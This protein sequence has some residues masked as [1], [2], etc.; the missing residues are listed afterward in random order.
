MAGDGALNPC[1]ECAQGKCANCIGE[2]WDPE[3][4]DVV[5]VCPCAEATPHEVAR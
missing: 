3:A 5:D 1:P 4:D 2:T